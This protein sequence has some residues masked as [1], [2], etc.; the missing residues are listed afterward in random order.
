LVHL[1]DGLLNRFLEM[2]PGIIALPTSYRNHFGD[3]RVTVVAMASLACSLLKSKR[4]LIRYARF[5]EN[6]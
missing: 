5:L 4:P 6:I 2:P 1:V 3:E